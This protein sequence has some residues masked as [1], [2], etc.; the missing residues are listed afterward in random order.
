MDLN[1]IVKHETYDTRGTRQVWTV[2]HRTRCCEVSFALTQHNISSSS[3]L[4]RIVLYLFS[5]L[6]SHILSLLSLLP[7]LY[8]LSLWLYLARFSHLIRFVM[9]S[10]IFHLLLIAQLRDFFFSITYRFIPS[11]CFFFNSSYYLFIYW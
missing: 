8:L 3:K 2:E 11:R 9:D 6:F 4:Y 7:S 5:T 10:Y 1:S